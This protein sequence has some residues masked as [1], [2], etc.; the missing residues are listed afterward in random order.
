MSAGLKL[1][2][3]CVAGMRVCCVFLYLLAATFALS[4]SGNIFNFNETCRHIT[5]G[6]LL[7]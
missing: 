7:N 4:V 1:S 3:A 5:V 6:V 2:S